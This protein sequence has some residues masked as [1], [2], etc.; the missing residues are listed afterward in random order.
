MFAF[1][2]FV[3]VFQYSAKRLAGKNVSRNDLFCVEWDVKPQ[4]S[5]SLQVGWIS[6]LLTQLCLFSTCT[7]VIQFPLS[8]SLYSF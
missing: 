2:V 4:L 3:L 6:T 5:Q 7:W 8:F 1:V